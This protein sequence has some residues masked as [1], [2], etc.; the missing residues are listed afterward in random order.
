MKKYLWLED[1]Q[2]SPHVE[3]LGTNYTI[4]IDLAVQISPNFYFLAACVKKSD[5]DH[6][7]GSIQTVYIGFPL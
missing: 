6:F 3:Y 1:S 2:Q 5:N 7:H 4:I